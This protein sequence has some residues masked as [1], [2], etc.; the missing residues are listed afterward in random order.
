MPQQMEVFTLPGPSAPIAALARSGLPSDRFLFAG[1]LP[2]KQAARCKVLQ[3]LSA[4]RTTLIFFET[5]NRIAATLSDIQNVL[6][7]RE[8]A[9]ARE[10][11]KVYEELVRGTAGELAASIGKPRGKSLF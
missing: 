8:V 10:L 9:V 1:F 7:S 4:I 5:G 11:T 6:G 3:E 2:P